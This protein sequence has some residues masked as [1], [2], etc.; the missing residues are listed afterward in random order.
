[1]PTIRFELELSEQEFETFTKSMTGATVVS[2]T[3]IVQA[4]DSPLNVTG[5]TE[6]ATVA[7]EVLSEQMVAAA[8]SAN[9]ITATGEVDDRGVVWSEEVH[10]GTKVKNKDGSWRAKRGVDKGEVETYE[11]QFLSG[12]T[13]TP[14]Q[15]AEQEE[16]R[17]LA[18]GEGLDIPQFLRADQRQPTA[19]NP[20]A[21]VGGAIL[22]IPGLPPVE[23][24][25][26]SVTWEDFCNRVA[27]MTPIIGAP[28]MAAEIPK[29]YAQCGVSDDFASLQ[30]N[31][32]QRVQV[33]E[34]LKV[35]VATPPA[36]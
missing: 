33:L 1:M 23:A 10:A 22:G 17:K 19:E 5:A 14:E 30:T 32:T 25:P 26:E 8:A 3:G 16:M 7:S 24:A 15:L 11:N 35:L 20:V 34:Q 12:T 28:M 27:E 13:L 31:E 9:S 6:V 36:G 4:Y 18:A 29:I 2:N 21:Q